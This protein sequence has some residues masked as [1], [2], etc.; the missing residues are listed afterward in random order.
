LAT[1]YLKKLLLLFFIML[2]LVISICV[3]AQ[4]NNF[5]IDCH[6]SHFADIADCITCHRGIPET[7]RKELAHQKLIKGKYAK[8][9]L[10][11][12]PD[13]RRGIDLINNSGCRRC[14]SIGGKGNTL[15]VS[16]NSSVENITVEE[17]ALAI[18]K[19]NEFMPD[20]NFTSE[21]I[22][23]IINGLLYLSFVNKD[24]SKD[25]TQVVHL[26]S[27]KSNTFSKKCGNCHKMISS[28]RGPIGSG[29]VAPNLSGLFSPYYP[30]EIDGKKWDSKLLEKWLKN[31]RQLSSNALMPVLELSGGEFTEIEE[32]FGE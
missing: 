17:I 24:A 26:G 30:R 31:P 3:N 8:F 18:E 32:T 2:F 14:H 27:K 7:S 21:Q 4:N 19:P 5:C 29:Y 9:L 12:F 28:L 15:S 25:F 13:K 6:N 11:E 16:L 20:F 22:T 23:Y 10:D 1:H